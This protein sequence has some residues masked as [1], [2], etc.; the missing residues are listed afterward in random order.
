MAFGDLRR[1]WQKLVESRGG[2]QE[3]GVVRDQELR[4]GAEAREIRIEVARRVRDEVMKLRRSLGYKDADPTYGDAETW[5]KD[6]KN[7]KYRSE[8]DGSLINQH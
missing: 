2:I 7:K 5:A 6:P 4:D 1:R 3:L 8:V